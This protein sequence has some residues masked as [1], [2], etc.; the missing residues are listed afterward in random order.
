MATRENEEESLRSVA[1]Q[2][3]QSIFLARQRAEEELIRTKEALE[4]KTQELTHS[5]AM[6]RATLEATSN[7]ILVTDD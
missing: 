2:N 3:T 1:L 4:V 6:M 5:L 7:G